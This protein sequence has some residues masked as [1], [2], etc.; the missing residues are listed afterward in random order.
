MFV[1]MTLLSMISLLVT[2]P[3]DS[4]SLKKT[5]LQASNWPKPNMSDK[6][7]QL[8]KRPRTTP[9]GEGDKGSIGQLLK[10]NLPQYA[11][12]RNRQAKESQLQDELSAI[13]AKLRKVQGKTG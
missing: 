5:V 1:F 2:P 3:Q 7:P 10:H 11:E 12:E 6:L 8:S 4:T 9:L 13:Q